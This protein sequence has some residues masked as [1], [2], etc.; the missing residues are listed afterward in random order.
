MQASDKTWQAFYVGNACYASTT[1]LVK[2]SLLCQ[3]M[4]IFGRGTVRYYLCQIMVVFVALWGFAFSF[5]AWFPCFPVYEFWTSEGSDLCYG[6]GSPNTMEYVSTFE[7]QAGSNMVLDLIVLA[8]PI[9]LYFQK[10]TPLRSR[11]AL[12]VLLVMGAV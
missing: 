7:S 6:F 4:R 9:S 1:T 3:Y 11:M 10:E 12:L 8:L 5:L 2:L